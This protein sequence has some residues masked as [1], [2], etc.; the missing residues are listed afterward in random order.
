MQGSD[1]DAFDD[2][3]GS[4]LMGD[5]EDRANLMAMNELQREMILA[6]RAE[7]RDMERERLR[8]AKLLRQHQQASAQVCGY[9]LGLHAS[10]TLLVLHELHDFCIVEDSFKHGISCIAG[11]DAAQSVNSRQA[12]G[13]CKVERH[14]RARGREGRTR[15]AHHC[16]HQVTSPPILPPRFTSSWPLNT[17]PLI[18]ISFC[19]LQEPYCHAECQYG[20]DRAFVGDTS[21]DGEVGGMLQG[22]EA[23]RQGLLVQ[24]GG[25]GAAERQRQRQ[26]GAPEQPRGA[27]QP[28][29]RTPQR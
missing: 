18:G 16:P 3:Y 24:R 15:G 8:N 14:G 29:P 2:G 9:L 17:S 10:Q 23:A 6:E 25:R 11:A 4:D 13:Q 21:L 20:I 1:E 27:Q 22:Q 28:R 5:E 19:F 7:K 12:E 26:V